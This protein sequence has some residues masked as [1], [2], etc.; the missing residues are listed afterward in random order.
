MYLYLLSTEF[1]PC[2]YSLNNTGGL[3]AIYTVFVYI[4]I[5]LVAR[6]LIRKHYTSLGVVILMFLLIFCLHDKIP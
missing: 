2:H 6:L 3:L 5:D 1:F 4:I